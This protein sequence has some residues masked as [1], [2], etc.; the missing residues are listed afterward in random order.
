[1]PYFRI[2]RTTHP[3]MRSTLDY[4]ILQWAHNRVL[5]AELKIVRWWGKSPS[6]MILIK[7]PLTAGRVSQNRGYLRLY[8]K[9]VPIED[10][11]CQDSR[12][13]PF[14]ASEQKTLSAVGA[15]PILSILHWNDQEMLY[16]NTSQVC[17]FWNHMSILENARKSGQGRKIATEHNRSY[18]S[19][20]W[21]HIFDGTI[22]RNAA[23]SVKFWIYIKV[24]ANR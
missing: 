10:T 20:H 5:E 14:L 9:P 21:L 4:D 23:E 12:R 2:C 8:E 16:R 3:R 13:L 19:R 15:I 1:M 11:T 7:K 17:V 6:H 18:K 22:E 24:A